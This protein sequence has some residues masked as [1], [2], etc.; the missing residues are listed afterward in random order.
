MTRRD[1]ARQVHLKTSIPMEQLLRGEIRWWVGLEERLAEELV[2]QPNA[3]ERVARAMVTSRLRN[4]DRH[5][6]MAVLGF[7]GSPGVGKTEMARSLAE[8]IFDN[9]HSEYE[10]TRDAILKIT[11]QSKLLEDNYALRRSIMLRNP[12]V[13]PLNYAKFYLLQEIRETEEPDDDLIEAF[14][15]SVNGIAAGLKNTG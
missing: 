9:I 15:M 14:T 1:I 5:R 2:G 11:D 3:T 7:V 4:A 12:Y 6:P 8:E 10:R 13:D